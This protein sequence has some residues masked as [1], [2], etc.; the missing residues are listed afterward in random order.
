MAGELVLIVEDN[1]KNRKLVREVL[2]LKGYETL[3]ATTAEAGLE[4][5]RTQKPALILMDIQL[6]GI[7][8]VTALSQLKADPATSTIPVMAITASAMLHDL[9][10]IRHA[11]FDAYQTKPINVRE[12]VKIVQKVLDK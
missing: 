6:P 8:G 9:E 7:D 11:G 1:D 5:A 2:Q 10:R 4:L 12:F 3:E